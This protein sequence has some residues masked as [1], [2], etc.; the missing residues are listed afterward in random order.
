MDQQRTSNNANIIYTLS[1]GRNV[2]GFVLPSIQDNT[3]VLC[4]GI[5]G[6]ETSPN[7]LDR[8]LSEYRQINR[9]T[10][11]RV[12]QKRDDEEDDDD[13]DDDDDECEDDDRRKNFISGKE[14]VIVTNL[15]DINRVP[16]NETTLLFKPGRQWGSCSAVEYSTFTNTVRYRRSIDPNRGLFFDVYLGSEA[17][18]FNLLYLLI[19]L[20]RETSLL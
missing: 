1:D 11:R 10:E 12:R 13:D 18:N 2:S 6:K 8:S 3:T 4:F 15:R 7:G 19:K 9:D 16:V 5:E 14:G 20:V 17:G